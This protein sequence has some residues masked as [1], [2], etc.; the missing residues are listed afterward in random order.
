MNNNSF[1]FK[2]EGMIVEGDLKEEGKELPG[3][4]VI[5]RK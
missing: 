3:S 1:R 4:D 2:E 5:K